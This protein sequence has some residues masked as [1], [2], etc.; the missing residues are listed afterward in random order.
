MI[1]N[2]N[3]SAAFA[4][5]TLAGRQSSLQQNIE[6]LSSGQRINRGGD[7]ASGLAVSVTLLIDSPSSGSIDAVTDF[8]SIPCGV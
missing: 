3:A 7:D 4:N 8:A 5:R 1:I 6:Q 2:H